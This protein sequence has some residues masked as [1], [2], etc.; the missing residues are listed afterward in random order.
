LGGSSNESGGSI[1]V[2]FAIPIDEARSVAEEII[3]TG[4]ATHP[5]IGVEA[6]NQLG[7]NGEKQGARLTRVV[8]GGPAADADLQVG[9]VINKVGGTAVGSVDELILAL[10]QNK[11]GDTVTLTYLR[12]GQARETRVTLE[13]KGSS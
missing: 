2:G 6:G 7:A 10:R 4:R 12:D 3:R 1:G 11:V 8:A 13:N 5:A 9:D